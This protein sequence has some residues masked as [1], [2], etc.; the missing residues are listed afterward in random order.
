[1]GSLTT[2]IVLA[3][4]VVAALV[5]G[6][7]CGPPKVPPGPNITTNYNAP[8][9]PARATWYGQ[10]YGSGPADNGGACGI[11]NVNLPPYN[12]M[13]SCGNVPIFKDGRG[14]GS[15]YEVKCEQPAACSKQ[16]VTVFITDMNYEPIS[17]YHFDF[18]GKAFGAMACPGKET[19]LRKAGIIDMQF[20]RVRC[21]YP[22]GQKVT[23]HV[24][25][26]SNPNYLAVLVKFVADDGDVIQMDLQ[27]AG[28]PAWRPMKLSWGAIW[29]MDTATPLKAPFSIRVTTESGKSLIA[30]DVIPVNWMPDAVYVSNVQFC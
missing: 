29:R 26:G 30:K 28:L 13:I 11:K 10:P 2:N 22:S 3:V 24:E 6:G 12:G 9:L 15:C 20:R 4:A 25:K 1:M 19:E 18:S 8:W 21:K 14:C 7:S 5:G 16:P 23:F 17:A 27:E